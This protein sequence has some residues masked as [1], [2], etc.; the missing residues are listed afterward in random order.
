MTT[1]SN[2]LPRTALIFSA[3]LG[4]RFKPWTDTH[5]KAL[6]VI[7]GKSLLQRNIEYLQQYGIS[8]VIVNVHH[9]ADQIVAAVKKNKGW[10][11]EVLISDETDAVLET[12]GGLLKAKPLFTPSEPFITC[13]ADILTDLDINALTRFHNAGDALISMM[14]SGRKTSRYLLF[15]EANTLCG[16]RNITTGEERISRTAQPMRQL[17]YDCVVLFNYAVFDAIPFTGKFSLIDL[18]LHLAKEHTLKGLE[19]KDDRWVDV[20]KPESVAVAEALF[21]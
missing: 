17:A 12:G 9:F 11:S 2:S 5:P 14:V 1:N 19:H 6:A 18:Y 21:S 4:T 3:G 16:W 7:N 8:R 10:G 15:D 20:G 13:N